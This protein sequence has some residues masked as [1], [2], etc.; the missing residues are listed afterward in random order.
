MSFADALDNFLIIDDTELYHIGE[1]PGD[2]ANVRYILHRGDPEFW[3]LQFPRVD[4]QQIA[5][6]LIRLLRWSGLTG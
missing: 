5:K 2:D 3:F 1:F 6:G 4:N